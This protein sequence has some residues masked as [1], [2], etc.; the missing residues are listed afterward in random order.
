MWKQLGIKMTKYADPKR[1]LPIVYK[2]GNA[3]I[4]STAHLEL[5]WPSRNLDHKF[6]D[7]F[8]IQQLLSPT[9]LRLMHPNNCKTHSKMYV[10]EVERFV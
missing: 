6:I 4:L 3:V 9:V 10:A 5:K 7:S 8:Q 1:T 2:V